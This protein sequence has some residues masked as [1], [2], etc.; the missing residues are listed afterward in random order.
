MVA[1]WLR[2]ATVLNIVA[3]NLHTDVAVPAIASPN[4][5]YTCLDAD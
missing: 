4:A 5:Q 1:S 2:L 3:A